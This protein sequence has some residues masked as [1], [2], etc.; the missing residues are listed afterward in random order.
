MPRR[1]RTHH[2]AGAARSRGGDGAALDAMRDAAHAEIALPTAA[3]SSQW[4]AAARGIDKLC[5]RW[6]A[7]QGAGPVSALSGQTPIA[8]QARRPGAGQRLRIRGLTKRGR[9]L[10][11]RPAAQ[12]TARYRLATNRLSAAGGSTASAA[13][14]VPAA[15]APS[16]ARSR[17]LVLQRLVQH[18]AGARMPPP[19]QLERRPPWRAAWTSAPTCRT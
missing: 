14:R 6:P 16:V 10:Y 15:G 2:A 17:Q 8:A 5:R 3:R 1:D 11:Q 9:P 12:P 13:R 4:T 7:V 19:L 18:P